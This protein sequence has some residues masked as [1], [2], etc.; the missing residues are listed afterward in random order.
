MLR[1]TNGPLALVTY[2]TFTTENDCSAEQTQAR[3]CELGRTHAFDDP[4]PSQRTAFKQPH[5]DSVTVRD[6]AGCGGGEQCEGS[7]QMRTRRMS[8]AVAGA[9]AAI[10]RSAS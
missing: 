1:D 9:G 8:R 10:G 7:G 5:P 6:F 2:G 3:S 4:E